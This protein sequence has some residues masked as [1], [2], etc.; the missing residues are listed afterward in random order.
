MVREEDRPALRRIINAVFSIEAKHH[1]QLR[2]IANDES[3][4]KSERADKYIDFIIDR[5]E[6]VEES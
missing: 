3:I 4:S 6:Y 2:A 5:M 1:E